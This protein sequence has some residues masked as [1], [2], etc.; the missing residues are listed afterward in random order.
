MTGAE[1]RPHMARLTKMFVQLKD[2][3]EISLVILSVFRVDCIELAGG[4]A[5]GKQWGMEK[6]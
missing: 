4:A 1:L 2:T 6:A 5:G 3:P